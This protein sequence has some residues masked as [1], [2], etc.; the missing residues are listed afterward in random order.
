MKEEKSKISS[1]DIS[2]SD[3]DIFSI[4]SEESFF[5][6]IQDIE[7]LRNVLPTHE[8]TESKK[9]QQVLGVT[10]KLM[11]TY[12]KEDI[13]RIIIEKSIE[14][15]G[16]ERGYLILIKNDG[17]LEVVY[18]LNMDSQSPEDSVQEISSTVI[19]KVLTEKE[20]IIIKDALNDEEYEVKRSIINLK[21]KAIMCAPMIKEGKVLGIIYVENRKI[22]G[23]FNTESAEVLKFFGNQCAVALENLDLIEQNK[24]Y[25][26]SLEKLVEERTSEL[27]YEKAFVERIIENI[28]EILIAVDNHGKIIKMNNAARQILGKD[29]EGYIGR[30]VSDFYKE[31]SYEIITNAISEQSNVSNVSCYVTNSEG[32]DVHFSA[33]MRHI[34]ENSSVIGSVIINKDMTQVEK[35]EQERLEKRELESIT[36]AAVT[37]NDQINTPL[38]VII[39]RASILSSL[40]PENEN[41]GKNV[42]IIKEQAHRIKN[43]LNEM[44]KITKVREKDYKLDGVRM[45]DLDE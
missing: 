7:N 24:K 20:A 5:N 18:S 41:I 35:Y 42:D 37:A 30:E 25:S 2:S 32:R 31:G 40:L 14:L 43:T 6:S 28:G 1:D 22:P 38:N 4:S 15:T 33:T 10:E 27:A 21:L 16:A 9:L 12:E 34:T 44:K 29:P 26:L 13:F 8:E 11:T 17:E 45:I 3:S 36:K 23:I 19:S 39:G